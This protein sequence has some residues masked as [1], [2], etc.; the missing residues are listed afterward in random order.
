MPGRKVPLVTN[1]IYHVFNRGIAKGVTFSMDSEYRRAIAT[2]S[3]YCYSEKP[4]SLSR[5]YRFDLERRNEILDSM[6]MTSKSVQVIC[7]C[8]MPNHFHLLLKQNTDGGISTYLSNFQNSYTRYFNTIHGRDGPIFL[9]QFKAVEIESESQLVHVSRY[10]H[11]NPY[12]VS[13][14]ESLDNLPG[15]PWSSLKSYLEG[16]VNHFVENEIVMS[17]FKNHLSYKKFVEDEADFR[18]NLKRNEKLLLDFG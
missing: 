1:C 12:V 9:N 2:L 11:L 10:I 7:Y 18:R 3:Y 6:S 15:Y 4:Y 13:L 14:V 8:L 5:L 17:L 16:G